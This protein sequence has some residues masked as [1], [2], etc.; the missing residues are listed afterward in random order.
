MTTYQHIGLLLTVVFSVG[1]LPSGVIALLSKKYF[2]L[3]LANIT[4]MTTSIDG[5]SKTVLSHE[6]RITNREVVCEMCGEMCP[7]RHFDEHTHMPDR[8]LTPDRRQ[9]NDKE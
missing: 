6:V 2:G 3:I 8:R 5:L 4:K 1:I 9:E 7:Y